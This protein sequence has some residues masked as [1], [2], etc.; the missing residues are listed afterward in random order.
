MSSIQL[1]KLKELAEFK[2]NFC[3]K[4][5]KKKYYTI[6]GVGLPQQVEHQHRQVYRVRKDYTDAITTGAF[7]SVEDI[8]A[9]QTGPRTFLLSLP[10]LDLFQR[11]VDT[12]ALLTEESQFWV[13]PAGLRF[14]SMDK[15]HIM[16]L[17]VHIPPE[18][19]EKF[20]VS[21]LAQ[22]TIRIED[23]KAILARGSK[24][25]AVY[26]SMNEFE[27]GE[28]VFFRVFAKG[29]SRKKEYGLHLIESGIGA[30]PLPKLDFDTTSLFDAKVLREVL[31]DVEVVSDQVTMHSLPEGV[32]FFGKSD[33]GKVNTKIDKNS[34]DI[35]EH[36][37]RGEAKGTYN[38]D[39]IT[40]FLSKM[41]PDVVSIQFT[42]K[43]PILIR[44]NLDPGYVDFYLAPRIADDEP[45]R[46]EPE[47]EGPAPVPEAPEAPEAPEGPNLTIIHNEDACHI[48]CGSECP[49]AG[50]CRCECEECRVDCQGISDGEDGVQ[51]PSQ[52]PQT[53]TES[54]GEEGVQTE[55]EK[56][57]VGVK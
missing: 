51:E 4:C 39:L 57:S 29:G 44:V 49:D 37:C 41:K 35:L 23:L 43:K 30:C 6:P 1:Q 18:K 5:G 13:G 24:N 3:G 17:D 31:E 16:L 46:S 10:S 48:G 20:D 19:C 36:T 38:I 7:R 2:K 8:P 56:P 12:I 9:Y 32:S 53:V 28:K 27:E 25:E 42:S 26:I 52:E 40:S 21:A 11:I 50:V 47:H 33:V 14:T 55:G 15:S 54:N 45:R 22:F 34:A